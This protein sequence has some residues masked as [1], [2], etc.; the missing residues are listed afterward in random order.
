MDRGALTADCNVRRGEVLAGN[1]IQ[2]TAGV[3]CGEPP[4]YGENAVKLHPSHL[5]CR[6][7]R[8]SDSFRQGC[9]K[10]PAVDLFCALRGTP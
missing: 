8:P 2:A 9:R 3:Q 6:M 5:A 7:R 1:T 10:C 4:K